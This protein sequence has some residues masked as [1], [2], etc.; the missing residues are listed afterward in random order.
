MGAGEVCFEQNGAVHT[1]NRAS[2]VVVRTES[3]LQGCKRGAREENLMRQADRAGSWT[4]AGGSIESCEYERKVTSSGIGA[5]FVARCCWRQGVPSLIEVASLS[6]SKLP[7][8]RRGREVHAAVIDG[9]GDNI[10]WAFAD[11]G[12]NGQRRQ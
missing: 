5:K 12:C 8:V 1:H 6:C 11:S 9:S 10:G 4:C 3:Q 2:A 7:S